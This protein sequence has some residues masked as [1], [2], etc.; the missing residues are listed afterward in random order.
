MKGFIVKL[1]SLDNSN[2]FFHTSITKK[3]K[4]LVYIYQIDGTLYTVVDIV[5]L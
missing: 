1:Y 4:Q 2:I 3:R 5:T